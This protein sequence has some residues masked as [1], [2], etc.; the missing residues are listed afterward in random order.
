MSLPNK[1][2]PRQLRQLADFLEAHPELEQPEWPRYVSVSYTGGVEAM[3]AA[4]KIPG[5]VKSYDA[6]H[7]NVYVE[8]AS[9][10]PKLDY[11][12]ARAAVCESVET[13]DTTIP[14]QPE[15]IIKTVTKWKCHPLLGIDKLE[16]DTES[17]PDYDPIAEVGF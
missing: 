17:V 7:L 5:A 8:I 16:K 1:E 3:I 10:L 2:F 14:A 15:R 9:D 12:I 6:T 4:A 13:V 11:F